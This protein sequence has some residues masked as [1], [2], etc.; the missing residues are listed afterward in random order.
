M[1][2]KYRKALFDIEKCGGR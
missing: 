1:S 2:Q